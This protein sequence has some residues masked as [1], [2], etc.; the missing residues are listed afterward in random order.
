MHLIKINEKI[1]LVM[2]HKILCCTFILFVKLSPT[3]TI[4]NRSTFEGNSTQISTN[5][6]FERLF[7]FDEIPILRAAFQ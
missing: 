4:I 2:S 6:C 7:K 3:V 5:P 1:V